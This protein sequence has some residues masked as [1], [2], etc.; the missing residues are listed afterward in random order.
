MNNTPYLAPTE[1]PTSTAEGTDK[2]M[3]HGQLTTS[4]A[5]E[6]RSANTAG[7]TPSCYDMISQQNNTTN[8]IVIIS[9]KYKYSYSS[10]EVIITGS[11]SSSHTTILSTIKLYNKS[12]LIM[13]MIWS[14]RVDHAIGGDVVPYDERYERDCDDERSEYGSDL[15]GDPL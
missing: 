1:V 15:V 14:Y 7:V 11:N 5:R 8:H 3:A 9:R 13:T 4:K 6:K 2:L 12:D 10:G